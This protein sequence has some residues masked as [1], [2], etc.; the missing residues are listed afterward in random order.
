MLKNKFVS[1]ILIPI[2]LGYVLGFDMIIRGFLYKFKNR[3]SL[4]LNYKIRYLVI[5]LFRGENESNIY[6]QKII[7][8]DKLW[9]YY[10]LKKFLYGIFYLLVAIFFSIY[11]IKAILLFD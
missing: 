6:K 5:Y 11:H 4:E 10:G 8:N 9:R 3:K 1:I 2:A 7:N